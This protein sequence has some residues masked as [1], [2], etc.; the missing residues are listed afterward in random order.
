SRGSRSWWVSTKTGVVVRGVVP[1]K[2]LPR[3]SAPRSWAATEHVSTHDCGADVLQPPFDDRIA[4]VH[5]AAFHA[6]HLAKGSPREGPRVEVHAADSEWVLLALVGAGR[7]AVQRN[8]HVALEFAHCD[9]SISGLVS[10]VNFIRNTRAFRRRRS[11]RLAWEAPAAC[12][13][14][15]RRADRQSPG[16]R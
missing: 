7:V 15:R 11:P 8:H 12:R 4:G 13:Q 9:T 14:F 3:I 6:L 2:T 10:I 1:P 16:K 5:L